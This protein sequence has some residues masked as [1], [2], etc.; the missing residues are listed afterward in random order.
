MKKGYEYFG[1]LSSNQQIL[2]CKNLTN[3]NDNQLKI[4]TYLLE[5]YASE[6]EF[7]SSAFVWS[8][9]NEGH[10][11]WSEILTIWLSKQD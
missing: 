5:E 7:L 1:K 6:W 10:S 4:S 11:Y 2:F 9:S 8:E 3:F